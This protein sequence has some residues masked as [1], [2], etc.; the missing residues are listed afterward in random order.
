MTGAGAYTIGGLLVVTG[1]GGGWL[2]LGLIHHI[3]DEVR[4]FIDV[5]GDWL[6]ENHVVDATRQAGRFAADDHAADDDAQTPHG[7]LI[8]SETTTGPRRNFTVVTGG[9]AHG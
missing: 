8:E 3:V 7:R 6:G 1:L 4:R 9:R 2:I 5:R